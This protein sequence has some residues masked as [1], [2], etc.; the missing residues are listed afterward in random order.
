MSAAV[1]R[2]TILE[3]RS[4]EQEKTIE[5]LSGQIAEQWK[6]IESLR[7]RLDAFVNRFAALE[8]QVAPDVP[9]TKP[10]HW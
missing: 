5:E 2:M 6:T 4:A 1:D 8:E 7:R 9:V 3:I 10:P